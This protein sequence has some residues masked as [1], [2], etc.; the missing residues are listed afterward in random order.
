MNEVTEGVEE[1]H[2][3]NEEQKMALDHQLAELDEEIDRLRK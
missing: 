2:N 1:D 3:K